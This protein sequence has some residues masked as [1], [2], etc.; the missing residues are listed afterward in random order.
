MSMQFNVTKHRME[1]LIDGV[2]AVALTIL[3]LEIK[4]PELADPR[5]GS[6]LMHALGHHLSTIVA[7]FLSFAML[8]L[9]WV[10]HHQLSHKVREI[11]GAMMSCSLAFLALVSFYPFAAA[12][13]SRYIFSGN[14]Y[15]LLVFLPTIGL[16]LLTQTLYFTLAM[17]RGLVQ[18]GVTQQEM[19]RAHRSNL[20][21]NAFFM[22]SAIPAALLLGVGAAIACVVAAALFFWAIFRARP[23]PEAA[24]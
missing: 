1:A 10:W 3:V 12:L 7:Y 2:F 22:L 15:V 24:G 21:G 11:D 4:V 16:I 18:A 13:F 5:S 8:G 17:R 19:L 14:V 20:Y 9:F 6:E 23:R